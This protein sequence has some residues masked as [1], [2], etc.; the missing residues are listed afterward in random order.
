MT[1][2]NTNNEFV[3][4]L[5]DYGITEDYT[6]EQFETHFRENREIKFKNL[7]IG[8]MDWKDGRFDV[9]TPSENEDGYETLNPNSFMSPC[10]AIN[11]AVDYLVEYAVGRNE[12]G[13]KGDSAGSS[14]TKKKKS[15][16]K[17]PEYNGPRLVRVFGRDIYIEEDPKVSNE[18]IRQK[19]VN[20]YNFPNFKKEKVFFD[21][22]V[23]TG[24]LE[25]LLKFQSKG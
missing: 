20:E 17:E 3:T 24:T 12:D 6:R 4:D 7:T 14:S 22:D 9:L 23:S 18:K 16:P 2:A 21:L 8:I 1:T 10:D 5:E 19:L 25:V 15:K 13:T 11:F